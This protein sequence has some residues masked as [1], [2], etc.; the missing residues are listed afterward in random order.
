MKYA[1]AA[2]ALM[3]ETQALWGFW[4][5]SAYCDY[6]MTFI[7]NTEMIRS[8]E[9]CTQFCGAAADAAYYGTP[10]MTWGGEMCCDY[11]EWSDGTFNCNLFVGGYTIPYGGDTCWDDDT[12]ADIDGDICSNYDETWC[13]GYDD[14]DFSSYS[15]C[16]VCGGGFV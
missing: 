8:M 14:D 11:E 7:D 2:V 12:T 1:F 13:G 16:C 5:T 9:D 15:Q 6:S 10:E 3:T 4:D